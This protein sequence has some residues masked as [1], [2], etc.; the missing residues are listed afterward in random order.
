MTKTSKAALR[1][2]IVRTYSADVREP[3]AAASIEGA[4]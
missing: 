1:P 3:E 2:V 4:T